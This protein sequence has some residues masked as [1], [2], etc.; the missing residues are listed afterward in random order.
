MRLV[1][2][3]G[4]V[5]RNSPSRLDRTDSIFAFLRVQENNFSTKIDEAA[6]EKAKLI[7]YFSNSDVDCNHLPLGSVADLSGFDC[8]R[9]M[10]FR[11]MLALPDNLQFFLSDVVVRA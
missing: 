1:P 6:C 2:E 10:N 9:G 11:A 4:A 5:A 8:D 7:H 3:K